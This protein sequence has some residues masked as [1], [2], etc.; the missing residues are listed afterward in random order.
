MI[1]DHLVVG[2]TDRDAARA[3]VEDALGVSMQPGGQHPVFHTHNALMALEDGIY[4]EAI[5]PNPAAPK[6]ARPRWFDLDRFEGPPRL[7]NWVCA[8]PDMEAVLPQMPEGSGTPVDLQRG[9][10]TWRMAVSSDGT[11][12][13]DCLFPAVIQWTAGVHPAKTLT[14]TGVRLRRLTLV[15]P[16]GDALAK[17]VGHHLEDDRIAVEVGPNALHAAFETPNGERHL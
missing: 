2:G 1:L 7:S 14:Q 12:P 11:T 10:L 17:A 3:H 6:P 4:L 16:D 9:D 8:V 15:H 5:A 13:F